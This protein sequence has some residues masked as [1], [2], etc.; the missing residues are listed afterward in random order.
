M[1]FFG[2]MSA[3][4]GTRGA[5]QLP[6]ERGILLGGE[7]SSAGVEIKQVWGS[8]ASEGHIDTLDSLPAWA[9]PP[10]VRNGGEDDLG[11]L[12]TS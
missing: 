9:P 1:G 12:L 4:S 10:L 8:P 11:S 6:L 2:Y 3:P 5:V 7:M